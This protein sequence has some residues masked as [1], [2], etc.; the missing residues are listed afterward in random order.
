MPRLRLQVMQGV[1]CPPKPAGKREKE[2]GEQR[3]EGGG[4]GR[5]TGMRKGGG[6]AGAGGRGREG[7]A[8]K[9]QRAGGGGRALNGSTAPPPSLPGTARAPD[10]CRMPA[11]PTPEGAR[12]EGGREGRAARN[13]NPPPSSDRSVSRQ[14][15]PEQSTFSL[16]ARPRP[17]RLPRL[18][19]HNKATMSWTVYQDRGVKAF[20]TGRPRV[21]VF[22]LKKALSLIGQDAPAGAKTSPASRAEVQALLHLSRAHLALSEPEEALQHAVALTQVRWVGERS[23]VYCD[24]SW[25]GAYTFLVLLLCSLLYQG[26]R[27]PCAIAEQ[28]RAEQRGN[29]RCE[30]SRA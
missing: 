8:R 3:G 19:P 28:R 12:R 18:R 21:A 23:V 29:A 26:E 14:P 17:P 7:K 1:S 30:Q 24:A 25:R 6:R 16:R 11:L 20:H 4:R 5:G 22:C 15:E 27:K 2:G 13:R 10:C 9:I